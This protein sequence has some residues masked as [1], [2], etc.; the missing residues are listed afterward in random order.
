[1]SSKKNGLKGLKIYKDRQIE[2]DCVLLPYKGGDKIP[3]ERIANEIPKW[4]EPG[5]LLYEFLAEQIRKKYGNSGVIFCPYISN[6]LKDQKKKRGKSMKFVD[7]FDWENRPLC[8]R[9]GI[10]IYACL[11]IG[12]Y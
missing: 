2:N 11:W 1:M 6:K 5:E 9:I 10:F 4:C 7:L 3:E 12:T 8:R